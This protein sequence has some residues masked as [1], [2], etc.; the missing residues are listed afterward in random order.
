MSVDRTQLVFSRQVLLGL[1]LPC[2]TCAGSDLEHFLRHS[3][4]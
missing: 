1:H 3:R 4:S 2:E